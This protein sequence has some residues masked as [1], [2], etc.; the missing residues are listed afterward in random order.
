[1]GDVSAFFTELQLEEYTA[2]VAENEIDG[3][4]LLE[5]A[6]ADGLSDL[7]VTEL[8]AIMLK[9]ALKVAAGDL[10]QTSCVPV[11]A[12]DGSGPSKACSRR[13][14][15][16]NSVMHLVRTKEGRW[17]GDWFPQL[18]EPSDEEEAEGKS[19]R[20]EPKAKKTKKD[21]NAPMQPGTGYNLFCEADFTKV[22]TQR[23]RLL[24]CGYA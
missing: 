2:A 15:V 21:P 17:I 19:R 1:V 9:R 6:E 22:R 18:D 23:A 12:D 3:H 11:V 7:G 24:V 8:H 5:L 14:A 10:A 20:D 13:A 4:T 16:A